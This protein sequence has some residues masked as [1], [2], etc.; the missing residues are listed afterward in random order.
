MKVTNTRHDIGYEHEPGHSFGTLTRTPEA[1]AYSILKYELGF[2]GRVQSI[3]EKQMTVKTCVLTKVDTVVVE[4]EHDAEY[5]LMLAMLHHWHQAVED[6]D[7]GEIAESC[8][9]TAKGNALLITH[10]M[11]LLVGASR[12]KRALLL[13]LGLADKPKV[14]ERLAQVDDQ[15]IVAVAELVGEGC[16]YEEALD[17]METKAGEDAVSSS[18]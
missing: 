14:I 11:S 18:F 5:R 12:V 9:D 3:D 1:G 17:A 4:F 6:V 10:G 15:E 8:V 7:V 13:A 2:G 16:S